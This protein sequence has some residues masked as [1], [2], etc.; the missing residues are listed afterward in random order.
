MLPIHRHLPLDDEIG[1][2]GEF[3]VA[4]DAAASLSLGTLSLL[5]AARYLLCWGRNGHS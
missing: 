4:A 2:G 3:C 5:T 1:H